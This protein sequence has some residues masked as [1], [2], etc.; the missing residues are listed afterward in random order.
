MFLFLYLF[1]GELKVCGLV[2]EL[3]A[4]VDVSG[5]G[6]HGPSGDEAAFEKLV[7]VVTHD[8]AILAS[9]GLTLSKININI[10]KN[11]Q[12]IVFRGLRL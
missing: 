11:P 5:P 10:C 7:R 6:A 12:S 3:S 4:D 9:S 8:L 2:V 1:D